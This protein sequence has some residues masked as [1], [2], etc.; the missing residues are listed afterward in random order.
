LQARQGRKRG[1]LR[2]EKLR[3]KERVVRAE[4]AVK[5]WGEGKIPRR[6]GGNSKAKANPRI[7]KAR[8][9]KRKEG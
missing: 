6:N 9:T 5:R 7:E 2:K 1:K 4:E 8:A 3:S